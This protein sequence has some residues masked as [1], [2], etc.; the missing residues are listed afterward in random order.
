M[1]GECVDSHSLHDGWLSYLYDTKE[2]ESLVFLV[3]LFFFKVLFF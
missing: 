3:W 2:V 1:Y